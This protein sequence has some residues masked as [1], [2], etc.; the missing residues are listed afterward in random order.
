M[1]HHLS[2]SLTALAYS[3]IQTNLCSIVVDGFGD[4]ST[5][6]ISRIDSL[7]DITEVWSCNYP[8]SL[9]LFYSAI[10]DFLGFQV[11]EGEFKVM[12]LSAFGNSESTVAK[13]VFDLVHWDNEKNKILLDMSYFSYHTSPIN[14]YSAKLET[15][16]GSP[17]NP[18]LPLNPGDDNFQHFADIARGAQDVVVRVL[19]VI[20]KHAHNISGSRNFLFS[21]GVAMNSAALDKIAIM[22]EVDSIIVPPSPGDAGSAIGSAYYALLKNSKKTISKLPKPS[23][24]PCLFDFKSQ[25]KITKKIIKEN[26]EIITQNKDEAITTCCQLIKDG[27]LLKQY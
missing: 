22:S 15:V 2:H 17:R 12:G 4:R 24:F 16:L 8:V 1:D 13:K 25:N 19:S 18:Y 21:G 7:Y 9:G 23:L 3:D 27:N 14:S 11:N 5:A 20:F 26:F 10:T 6:S